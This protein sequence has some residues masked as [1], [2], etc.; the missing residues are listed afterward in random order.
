MENWIKLVE[1]AMGHGECAGRRELEEL[2][3]LEV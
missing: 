1:V 3:D 2:V